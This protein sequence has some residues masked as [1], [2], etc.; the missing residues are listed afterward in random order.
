MMVAV[1][2]AMAGTP[3]VGCSSEGFDVANASEVASA[4]VSALKSETGQEA[5]VDCGSNTLRLEV[6][7]SVDCSAVLNDGVNR[8]ARV[9]VVSVAGDSYSVDVTLSPS[10]VSDASAVSTDEFQILVANA[11]SEQMKTMICTGFRPHLPPN[12]NGRNNKN[13]THP[14]PHRI[15]ATSH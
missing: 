11:L 4:A 9:S 5:V 12:P 7:E 15:Q 14:I 10:F 1:G 3:I 6:G 2:S 13:H 8:S